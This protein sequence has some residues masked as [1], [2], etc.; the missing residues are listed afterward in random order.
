[1]G[2]RGWRR[3]HGAAVG[4]G[5]AIQ[6]DHHIDGRQPVE[7]VLQKRRLE[8]L[9]A[10][11]VLVELQ[12]FR[13]QLG[14]ALLQIIDP[15]QP[16]DAGDEAEIL[17]ADIRPVAVAEAAEDLVD[18]GVVAHQ[19]EPQQ[20]R[21]GEKA[22]AVEQPQHLDIGGG[23]VGHGRED[24]K[25]NFGVGGGASSSVGASSP[26]RYSSGPLPLSAVSAVVAPITR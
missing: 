12:R 18:A 11:L 13:Q 1:V 7:V 20:L 2:C 14:A 10:D 23:E 3:R 4:S 6:L 26:P 22:V 24:Q 16:A 21:V 19:A 17:L 25:V 8:L 15:V 5:E 9:V